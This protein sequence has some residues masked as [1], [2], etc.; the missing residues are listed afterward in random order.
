M[1]FCSVIRRV[2][3]LVP[4]QVELKRNWK[5]SKLNQFKSIKTKETKNE[6]ENVLVVQP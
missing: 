3:I 5:P 2:T 6:K 1:G 4:G